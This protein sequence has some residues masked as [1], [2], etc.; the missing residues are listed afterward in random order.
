MTGPA[1]TAREILARLVAIDTTS[2]NSNLPLVDMIAERVE[3]PGV[4]IHVQPTEDGAKA[5]LLAVAGPWPS[6]DRGGL[7]LCGHTDTVPAGE[8]GW[9]TDP[10]V[11]AEED[12]RLFGRGTA[13]MKGFLALAV[14]AFAAVDADRLARPLALLFTHDE[15]VGTLGARRFVESW[16]EPGALPRR[17]IVGEPTGL[18]VVRMHK[19]HARIRIEVEGIPAHS[20]YPHLGRSAIEPAARA[21]LALA[22][23]RETLAGERPPNA[24]FFEPVPF[25]TLNVGRVRGGVADNVV[26]D[27]CAI[28]VGGRPLPGTTAEDLVERIRDAVAPVLDGEAWSL[29]LV[30]ES[31]PMML[32]EDAE[33]HRWLRAEVGQRAT[34]AV[35]F[36]TDAGWLQRLGLDCVVFG[37]GSIEVAHKPNEFVPLDELARAREVLGRAVRRW[38]MVSA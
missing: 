4:R 24:E 30:N 2:A 28:D 10:F 7:V 1:P 8:P 12:E 3:R 34:G 32:D 23:L 37:P 6:P 36:A 29:A 25:V 11:L 31:P 14:D 5:N 22:E 26:P 19:G 17:T 38:C 20:A 27:R 15:E 16:E 33:L 35:S 13:D 9:R 18:A 21:I